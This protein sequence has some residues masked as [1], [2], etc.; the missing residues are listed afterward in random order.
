MSA[1]ARWL[2]IWI[3]LYSLKSGV[4]Q[5][6]ILLLQ[7]H[8]WCFSTASHQHQH[9][10]AQMGHAFKAINISSI[11]LEF[12]SF[13][14]LFF[15]RWNTIIFH[16]FTHCGW[17]PVAG[18]SPHSRLLFFF[19]FFSFSCISPDATHRK[20]KNFTIIHIGELL[21]EYDL[22]AFEP[23]RTWPSTQYPYIYIYIACH[24]SVLWQQQ[25]IIIRH[26]NW[27]LNNTNSDANFFFSVFQLARCPALFF[28]FFTSSAL[29]SVS[30]MNAVTINYQQQQHHIWFAAHYFIYFFFFLSFL[31]AIGNISSVQYKNVGNWLNIMRWMN[32]A[33]PNERQ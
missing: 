17:S 7:L 25:V 2:F 10:R 14:F 1:F 12:F 29:L 26:W 9:H 3:D 31:V 19:F 5:Y 32:V 18:L 21:H 11:F 13:I 22:A 20:N 15:V 4:W 6:T 28:S 24:M 8:H 30:C 27:K 33:E 16:Y 23:G